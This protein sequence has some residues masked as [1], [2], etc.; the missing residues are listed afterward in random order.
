[1][2]DRVIA[3]KVNF[4]MKL[5]DLLTADERSY[6]QSLHYEARSV[7]DNGIDESIHIFYRG[8]HR[9]R[10]C[11]TCSSLGNIARTIIREVYGDEVKAE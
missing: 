9:K 4:V 3:E 7:G 5:E 8:G 2:T 1:M 6:V 11:V 10:V